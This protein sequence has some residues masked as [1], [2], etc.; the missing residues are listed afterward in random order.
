MKNNQKFSTKK[1]T[2]ITDTCFK[3]LSR[4]Q[5]NEVDLENMQGISRV[6]LITEFY[7]STTDVEN[8]CNH[9]KLEESRLR[10]QRVTFGTKKIEESK[11]P[12]KYLAECGC[13][14][15]NHAGRAPIVGALPLMSPR[16]LGGPMSSRPNV[17]V[18]K[19]LDYVDPNEGGYVKSALQ[20]IIDDAQALIHQIGN[21]DNLPEW[22]QEKIWT[23]KDRINSAREYLQNKM[24]FDYD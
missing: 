13:Q 9:L 3:C 2:G 23:A 20:S 24:R 15:G 1:I 12:K 17:T 6:V 7:F 4:V 5:L 8:I 11:K 16:P 18:S 14:V 10:N 22:S 19:N 21:G